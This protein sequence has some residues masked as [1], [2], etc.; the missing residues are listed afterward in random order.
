[1]LRSLGLRVQ[2]F[3]GCF[4]V[5]RVR[6][7]RRLAAPAAPLL[8]SVFDRG[9]L[10]P[11]DHHSDHGHHPLS[12]PHLGVGCSPHLLLTGTTQAEGRKATVLC[13]LPTRRLKA[14]SHV[15]AD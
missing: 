6:S 1:M 4:W 13:D 5:F 9:V 15:A 14:Q 12:H 10:P 3:F 11:S 7:F 8:P 2:I